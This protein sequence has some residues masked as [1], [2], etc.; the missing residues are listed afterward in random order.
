MLSGDLP[1]PDKQG[2]VRVAGKKIGRIYLGNQSFAS[3][4]VYVKCKRPGHTACEQWVQLRHVTSQADIVKWLMLDFPDAQ[5][6]LAMFHEVVC[7]GV[8]PKGGKDKGK[9]KGKGKGK[10]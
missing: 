2:W 4:S 8:Q 1:K 5:S 9:G 3:A 6:H 10:K 7:G